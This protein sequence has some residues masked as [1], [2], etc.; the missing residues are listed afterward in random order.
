M[1]LPN[2][3]LNQDENFS[4][5]WNVPVGTPEI[6]DG[7]LQFSTGL[8]G[9]FRDPT[10]EDIALASFFTSDD[11]P[12]PWVPDDQ[13]L[14]P[15]S[16]LAVIENNHHDGRRISG[17]SSSTDSS[18]SASSRERTGSRLV[19]LPLENVDV[20]GAQWENI[21]D[22][23]LEKDSGDVLRRRSLDSLRSG[24]AAVVDREAVVS[25]YHLFCRH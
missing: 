7:T 19:D 20:C 16:T 15:T 22:M 8:V 23:K 6:L 9:A 18:L 14:N 1:N 10:L 3:A 17:L 24:A 5:L 12:P 11:N 21:E 2:N 25:I 13:R 4:S